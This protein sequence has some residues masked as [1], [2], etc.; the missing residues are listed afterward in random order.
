MVVHA[1]QLVE[2]QVP[3]VV[4]G[5]ER[6]ATRAHAGAGG[7]RQGHAAVTAIAPEAATAAPARRQEDFRNVR[8]VLFIMVFRFR[9]AD[10][11]KLA[12]LTALSLAFAS[13]AARRG[14]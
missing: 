1:E 2:G 14:R 9:P 13:I 4:H 8:L 7:A 3:R 10:E 5:A 6:V 11:A 12:R